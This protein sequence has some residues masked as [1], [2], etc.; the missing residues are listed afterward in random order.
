MQT[1]TRHHSLPPLVVVVWDRGFTGFALW[2]LLRLRAEGGKEAIVRV[3]TVSCKGAACCGCDWSFSIGRNSSWQA[4][5]AREHREAQRRSAFE[6]CMVWVLDE[7]LR[8]PSTGGRTGVAHFVCFSTV[9]IRQSVMT[10]LV[11]PPARQ[12]T[13]MDVNCPDE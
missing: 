3:L 1:A 9:A 4:S 2:F 7:G 5:N 12:K 11:A 13:K 8:V 10:A 6:E